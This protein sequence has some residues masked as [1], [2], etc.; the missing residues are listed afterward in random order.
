MPFV[1][2]QEDDTDNP[3]LAVPYGKQ[4]TAGKLV[5]YI[6][7]GR[8]KCIL[9]LG[10][11]EMD[12]IDQLYYNGALVP[13]FADAGSTDRNWKFHPGTITTQPSPFLDIVSV[14][15]TTVTLNSSALAGATEVALAAGVAPESSPFPAGVTQHQKLYVV[16]A[17]GNNITL[18]LTPGGP[19]ISW[20]TSTYLTTNVRLYE[21]N[22]G[23]FD[24]I[25]GRPEFFPTVDFTLSGIAY[26]EV[27]LPAEMSESEDEPTQFK[28]YVRGK[29]VQNYTDTGMLADALGVAY[30]PM[31]LPA[32]TKFMS[33]NN[34]LVALDIILNYMKVSKTRIDWP[35]FVKYRDHCDEQIAWNSGP[36]QILGNPTWTFLGASSPTLGTVISDAG[37]GAALTTQSTASLSNII[38]TGIYRGGHSSIGLTRATSGY[39]TAIHSGSIFSLDFS[40]DIKVYENGLLVHTSTIGVADG[41]TFKVEVHDNSANFYKNDTLFYSQEASFGSGVT[42]GFVTLQSTDAIFNDVKFF[43]TTGAGRNVNRFDAHVVYPS[44]V[45]CATALQLVFGH[46]PNCHWQDVNGKIKFIVGSD[47]KDITIGEVAESGDRVLA[48]VLSYDLDSGIKSNIV[49]DSFAAYKTPPESKPNFLRLELRDVDDIYFT[50][51]YVYIDRPELRD[52]TGN[53]VD[54]GIIPVGVASQSLADRLGEAIMRWGSDLDLFITVKGSPSTYALTKGDIVKFA[55]EVPNWTLETPVTFI[56][57]EDTLESGNDT[58]DEKSYLLQ[59]YNPEY[60]SD[61]AHGAISAIF[62]PVI[63]SLTP[64]PPPT[65]LELE[66]EIRTLESGINYSAILGT[67]H[68]DNTYPYSQRARVYWKKPGALDYIETSVVLEQPNTSLSVMPFELPFA[69]TGIHWIKVVTETLTGVVSTSYIIEEVEVMGLPAPPEPESLVLD[70]EVR[71]RVDESLYSVILGTITL[72]DSYIY[73]QRA[74][75]Y[76]KKPGELV[77]SPTGIV[78]D[79]TEIS[80]DT[81]TF[82]LPDAPVGIN[83][84][85]VITESMTGSISTGD[86][87]ESID[88]ITL[89]APPPVVS[90]VI[91]Q[92]SRV[93]PDGAPYNAIVGVVTFDISTY[94]YRQKARIYWNKPGDASGVYRDSGIVLS[95]PT[96]DT[97]E[98][99][100]N[101]TPADIG[102]NK[103]RVITESITGIV[104]TSPVTEEITIENVTAPPNLTSLV[105]T[106]EVRMND[107][108]SPY[109]VI[110]GTANFDLDYEWKQKVKIYKKRNV[111]GQQYRWTGIELE[112][113][114]KDTPSMTFEIPFSYLGPNSI[115][116]VTESFTGLVSS[117]ILVTDIDVVTLD[118]PPAATSVSLS[119]EVRTSQE[120]PISVIKGAVTF[121][122]TYTYPQ[123]AKIEWEKP[124]GSFEDTGI[125]IRQRSTLSNPARFEL[126]GAPEGANRIRVT[127]QSITG[128]VGTASIHSITVTTLSAPPAITSLSLTSEPVKSA[129]GRVLYTITGIVT[130]NNTGYPYRLIGKVYWKKPGDS[131]F[132]DTGI[133]LEQRK[134]S[135]STAGFQLVGAPLGSNEIQI[136]TESTTGIVQTASVTTYSTTVS[137]IAAP[138]APT[139]LTG[140]VELRK[141]HGGTG[142]QSVI[143][144]SL[145]FASGYDY[146][147]AATLYWNKPSSG[148]VYALIDLK[149]EQTVAG[150]STIT[151]ELPLAETGTHYLR[152][153]SKSLTNVTGGTITSSAIAVP[154]L[155]PP[156]AVTS[157]T[158][159]A[160]TNA[161]TDGGT[162]NSI[163][164][165]VTFNNTGY[166]YK[167]RARIYWRKPGGSFVDTGIM[168]EQLN[169]STSTAGF[170][171][172]DAPLGVNDIQAV[173]ESITGIIQTASITTYSTTIS[174]IAGPSAPTAVS[175]TAQ[176]RRMDGGSG[177][178][179]VIMGSV[180]FAS[181][182]YPQVARIYWNKPS[183]GSFVVTEVVLQ[184]TTAGAGTMTFE[185]PL[186]EAGIHQIRAITESLTGVAGG[187]TTSSNITVSVLGAPPV[188]SNV[189]LSVEATATPDGGLSN[190]INGTVTFDNT[191]YPYKVRARI[192]WQKPGGSYVDSGIMVEQVNTATSTAGF[193]L[194]DAPLGTNNI[195]ARTE[196]LNGT[197]QS[198]GISTYSITVSNVSGP[199][200][201]SSVSGTAQVRKMDGGSGQQTVIMGSVTFASYSYPQ[202]ARIYWNKPSSGSFVITEVV[203]QQ[204]TAGASTMTFELPLAE[205]GTHQIRAITESLTG[206]AGGTTTSSNITVSV[207]GAPPVVSDVALSLEASA[208]PDGGVTNNINGTITFDNTGFPY[209]IRGRVYWRK[210]GGSYVD[211]GIMVEQV[212]TSTSTAGFKLVDAPI[213]NNEVKVVTEGLNGVAQTSGVVDYFIVVPNLSAPSAP[214]AVSGTAQVRKMDG[215]TGQQTVIMGSVTF[216]S[217]PYPQI[218][219]I[220][221]NKPSSGSF[222][223]T[224]IVLRQTTAGASTM[225]FELPLAEAGTH[226]IRAITESLTGVA[227]GTTTS[228]NITVSVLGAPPV[229]SNVSLSV[230]AT[231]AP[232]GGLSNTINGTVT[233]DNTGYPYKVRARIWWQK[234]GGSYVDSGIMVEQVNTSTSTAGFKLV[235]APIGTNNIQARTEGLNGTIQSVGIA[236]YPVTVSNLSAPPAVT[237]MTFAQESRTQPD[238]TAINFI[239]GT[240]TFNSYGSIQRARIAWKKPGGS[241]V[242]TGIVLQQPSIGTSTMRFELPAAPVG[243]NELTATT[244]SLTGVVQ[245]ASVTS[246]FISVTDISAPP[247][248]TALTLIEETRTLPNGTNIPVIVGTVTFNSSYAYAQRGFIYWKKAADSSFNKTAFVLDSLPSGNAT[249]TFELSGA[250]VGV[251]QVKIVVENLSGSG[252]NSIT[253]SITISGVIQLEEVVWENFVN[254]ELQ[255]STNSVKKISATSSWN[256]SAKSSKA[257]SSG[258]GY[259]QF[260]LLDTSSFYVG[261]SN[262]NY[263]DNS[264]SIKYT[265]YINYGSSA[266]F[267]VNGSLIATGSLTPAVGVSYRIVLAGSLVQFYEYAA[268]SSTGAKLG[269][270]TQSQLYPLYVDTSIFTNGHL[271]PTVSLYGKL[272]PTSGL[273]VHWQ[274]FKGL[275]ASIALVSGQP[276]ETL[277]KI[278]GTNWATGMAAG[279]FSA[280]RLTGD[281]AVEWVV[282]ETNTNRIVGLSEVDSEIADPESTFGAIKYGFYMLDDGHLE[283]RENGVNPGSLNLGSYST[284]DI[285]R[286]ERTNGTIKF[287]KNGAVVYT[288]ATTSIKPLYMDTNFYNTGSTL[289]DFKIKSVGSYNPG[290]YA[291][292]AYYVQNMSVTD[293]RPQ[294]DGSVY[295]ELTG[296]FLQTTDEAPIQR[297]NVR[298]LNK[299]GTVVLSNTFTYTG[300]GIIAQ[301]FYNRRYA[302]PYS[303]AIF[304]VVLDNG[305]GLSSPLYVKGN[306]G[307]PPTFITTYSMPTL[308]NATASVTDLVAVASSHT[309]VTLNWSYGSNIQYQYRVQGSNTWGSSS[310]S[311]A[312]PNTIVTGLIPDTTYEFRAFPNGTTAN[313]SNIAIVTT[314]VAPVVAETYPAPTNATAV[315]DP[316][317]PTTRVNLT[318]TTASPSIADTEIWRNGSLYDSGLI[319]DG[320]YYAGGL[321]AGT[322]YTFAFRHV[323]SGSHYSAL[324]NTVTITTQASTAPT[325]QSPSGLAAIPSSAYRINLSW[326][327][328]AASGTTSVERSLDGSSWSSIGSVTYTQT[329]YTDIGLD[330]ETTYYYRVKNSGV[331]GYSNVSIATTWMIPPS[332]VTLDTMVW[333]NINGIVTEIEA[334]YLEKGD[335]I[336]TVSKEGIVE[337]TK[338]VDVVKGMSDTLIMLSTKNGKHL[339]C[340]PSH[341]LISNKELQVV[342]AGN[343]ESGDSILTYSSKLE[344]VFEDVVES[345]E[346]LKGN[347][348]VL[349]LALEDKEHTFISNDIVS[350][351][352]EAK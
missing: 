251:N 325:S 88:V 133:R 77:F 259:M 146:P 338:L 42:R 271:V 120:T 104:S 321:S 192:W 292:P 250:D 224:E 4:I 14:S 306:G 207:I 219:R 70:Q 52:Q 30:N 326:T 217:Y 72:D 313:Y 295:F 236:T 246:Y 349:T 296:N 308:L 48:E 124:G 284:G 90:L 212:N 34:A 60:Y 299:F 352:L 196:G 286:I 198:V 71:I 173:T 100:F 148:G 290:Q 274:N 171:L 337:L 169:T 213:G 67:V 273:K 215:G 341:P 227:G 166:P 309:K 242:D 167:V 176:V 204:T 21:A 201:P 10:Q 185:L 197:V 115:K 75:I 126:T 113:L 305:I 80:V 78:L 41:D 300:N 317:T 235:D 130:F 109:S 106:Q 91:N 39:T 210:P 107:D 73:N 323:Y 65:A 205:P 118:P 333:V 89:T 270:T 85:K 24:P 216:A 61:T 226:Q 206:V 53:L 303:E 117:E 82:E 275:S 142:Y 328:N 252:T 288:S 218:A 151:F 203:L 260:T 258:D 1:L 257:L 114:T 11:G 19:A 93:M 38:I 92:E 343:I 311:T 265:A 254:S 193:K 211:T 140:T 116:A 110:L 334:K 81:L 97:E 234:P 244:E 87:T 316:A 307:A 330:P 314:P 221:W 195:Q 191:G 56:V 339:S 239:I 222:V 141:M 121:N 347:F 86:V 322:T 13:E 45:D 158:F 20:T 293:N 119:E 29:R 134:T 12:G 15:G 315:L 27:N 51:K 160:E 263:S 335:T 9:I 154:S 289:K 188:V 266:T 190:T 181:Y 272:E 153:T 267:Y 95:Q 291:Y 228:S 248:P 264:N 58:A 66:E 54:L 138:P 302:D 136:V 282:T 247:A 237:S 128:I 230:E 145:T 220:Y 137:N 31:A 336:V 186:A 23:F 243:S 101:L 233:F 199:P 177:Q 249:G 150:A 241:F 144:G 294:A 46:S 59:A 55:H 178:Q 159:S 3:T 123:M 47:Y 278:L 187:T 170:K 174:N 297:A 182:A 125:V 202:V 208:A 96:P 122:N 131:T 320:F 6:K 112:Q 214:T 168:L 189:S 99:D 261:F 161:S 83:E 17:S 283:P 342:K 324:S 348:E 8:M 16:G 37:S 43:P 143:V 184:Q 223:I 175:G 172:V 310:S 79:Q 329:Y 94:T 344:E 129:D 49:N 132:T 231:T 351:N 180:T 40:T 155:D 84:V 268:G 298:V 152:A 157:V 245:T 269:Q 200:A 33:A 2:R 64:P 102:L 127:T 238:G 35:S 28:I 5:Y 345:K 22:A 281:G 63:S 98:M 253:T 68:F 164:G 327:N 135:V 179:T 62:P 225:T 108:G 18:S 304:E 36:I 165:T 340:T 57:L 44:Q 183:S 256:A 32:Q 105:L 156:P 149:L 69:E 312:G 232:D 287:R 139:A 25:Q 319:D 240:V 276:V 277:T 163:N 103:V 162:N 280:E 350:H 194:V 76:W 331:N 209:K 229:V 285:L 74:R 26:V 255:I 262:Y 279:T 7:D 318:Y 332:C 50:K 346:I 111:F 147:Q 301:G